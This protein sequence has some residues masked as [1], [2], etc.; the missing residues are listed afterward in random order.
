MVADHTKWGVTGLSSFARLHELDHFITD[1]GLPRTERSAL[2]E[3]V[4][5]LVVADD[6]EAAAERGLI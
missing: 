6:P 4:G 1:A 5:E 2:A 3:A